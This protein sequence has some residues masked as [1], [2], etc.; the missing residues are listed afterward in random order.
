MNGLSNFGYSVSLSSH[1][2]HN[3]MIYSLNPDGYG[4]WFGVGPSLMASN[5]SFDCNQLQYLFLIKFYVNCGHKILFL[6]SLQLSSSSTDSIMIPFTISFL[7]DFYPLNQNIITKLEEKN[8][9]TLYSVVFWSAHLPFHST[10]YNNYILITFTY[11]M[12]SIFVKENENKTTTSSI[13]R[14]RS[15]PFRNIML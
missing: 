5:F 2:A 15:I 1:P 12:C 9:I 8:L 4:C 11:I 6:L 3:C 14:C 13:T 10:V 7:F